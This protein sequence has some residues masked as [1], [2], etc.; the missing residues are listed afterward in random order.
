MTFFSLQVFHCLV[1]IKPYNLLVIK[2]DKQQQQKKSSFLIVY[3]MS[4]PELWAIMLITSASMLLSGK[5]SMKLFPTQC[6]SALLCSSRPKRDTSTVFSRG[7][8]ISEVAGSTGIVDLP[9]WFPRISPNPSLAH[10]PLL[11]Q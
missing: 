3:C 8:T 6:S 1:Y 10:E 5:Q 4:G 9:R 2:C 7:T 11:C